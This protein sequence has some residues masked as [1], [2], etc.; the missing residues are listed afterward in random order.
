MA[1]KLHWYLPT[2]G[3]GRT[4]LL[5]RDTP[6]RRPEADEGNSRPGH[7]AASLEYMA[8]V[9]HAAEQTGFDAVLTPTGSYCDDAWITT[10]ALSQIV[11][12]LRFLV[13]LLVPPP[14]VK[15]RSW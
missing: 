9:A 5:A 7:R 13:A 1:I 6:F 14:G 12:R 10:A 4:L 15:R 2:H 3:D 11:D 8:Q